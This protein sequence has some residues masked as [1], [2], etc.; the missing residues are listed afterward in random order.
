MEYCILDALF[1]NASSTTYVIVCLA[2]NC[3]KL[4]QLPKI[5]EIY[6]S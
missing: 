2:A 5:K 4:L 3:D 6:W 1:P